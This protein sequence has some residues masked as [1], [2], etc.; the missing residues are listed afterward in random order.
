M[1]STKAHRL[2]MAI[3]LI[4]LA[5]CSK[6]ESAENSG[7]APGDQPAD[8]A[9]AAP[10]SH[11]LSPGTLIDAT[12][13]A[14]ISSQHGVAGDAFTALVASDVRDAAGTVVIP[15]GS[16]M[17][18][19]ITEVSPAPNDRS[20]GTLT[21]AVTGVT[22]GGRA[23]GVETSIDSLATINDTRGVEKADVARTA[24]GAAAGAILGKVIGGNG[25]GTII[26]AVAGAATGAAVSALV[27]DMDIVLPEGSHLMLTLRQPLPVMAQGG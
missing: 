4:L 23:Y 14:T 15:A 2:L 22:V 27:K 25:K 6:A 3:P 26:G 1:T 11:T 13:T 16:V 9:V 7:G 8:A 5:G 19:S 21:L 17:Q 12:T 24:G 10:S 18:G 20:A